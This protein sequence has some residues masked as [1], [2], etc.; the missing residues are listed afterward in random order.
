MIAHTAVL[1]APTIRG[2]LYV[3]MQHSAGVRTQQEAITV[4]SQFIRAG[5]A[6]SNS[7]HRQSPTAVED[8]LHAIQAS[9]PY[10]FAGL[11]A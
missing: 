10:F 4:L 2:L 1:D 5:P 3:T 6:G 7:L 11:R 9:K 8:L